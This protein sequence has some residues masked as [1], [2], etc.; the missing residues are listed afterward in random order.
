MGGQLCVCLRPGY[1]TVKKRTENQLTVSGIQI[2]ERVY[3]GTTEV[4]GDQYDLSA[5]AIDGLQ[6]ADWDLERG[7]RRLPHRVRRRV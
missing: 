4:Y 1:L 5:I 6:Q 3:D 2:K 7:P